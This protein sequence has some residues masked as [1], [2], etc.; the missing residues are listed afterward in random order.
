MTKEQA[1]KYKQK[2]AVDNCEDARNSL[3]LLCDMLEAGQFYP[4][5]NQYIH[6]VLIQMGEVSRLYGELQT[7]ENMHLLQDRKEHE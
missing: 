2:L 1:I 6:D 7:L 5:C 4:R 3:K